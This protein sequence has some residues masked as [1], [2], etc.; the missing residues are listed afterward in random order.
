[1]EPDGR[2]N[3][4]FVYHL[5]TNELRSN[6]INA[7]CFQ[8]RDLTSNSNEYWVAYILSAFEGPANFDR[9]PDIEEALLG[10][11]PRLNSLDDNCIVIF[12]RLQ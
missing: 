5:T 7:P 3:S 12:Q 11:T 10:I 6:N 2:D 1:M 4:R 9:D 8:T